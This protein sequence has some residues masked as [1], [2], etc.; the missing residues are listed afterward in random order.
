MANVDPLQHAAQ[1]ALTGQWGVL[2]AG[3]WRRFWYE[4]VVTAGLVCLPDKAAQSFYGP[5]DRQTDGKPASDDLQW[6]SP[7]WYPGGVQTY[8]TGPFMCAG[9]E[10]TPWGSIIWTLSAGLRMVLDT[11]NGVTVADAHKF[12]C[13]TWFDYYAP[14]PFVDKVTPTQYAILR[15]GY[16]PAHNPTLTPIPE[17]K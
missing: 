4:W 13:V 15:Y 14:G 5:Q 1:L 7:G 12:G 8:A 10:N 16:A 2:P 11:G 6:W 17:V 3:D 9:D